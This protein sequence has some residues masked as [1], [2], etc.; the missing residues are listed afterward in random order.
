MKP[1]LVYLDSSDYSNFARKAG[2][3]TE[4]AAIRE[5]LLR[6]RDEGRIEVRYSFA[7]VVEV[8]PTDRIYTEA[9]RERMAQIELICGLKCFAAPQV[10]FASE[11]KALSGLNVQLQLLRDDGNWFPDIF[12]EAVDFPTAVEMI[13]EQISKGSRH[14][15]RTAKARYFDSRGQ[16]RTTVGNQI[17]AILPPLWKKLTDN[18]PFPDSALAQYQEYFLGRSPKETVLEV[19]KSSLVDLQ[20]FSEWYEKKWDTV[21]PLSMNLRA[22]GE[23]MAKTLSRTQEAGV[24]VLEDLTR[25][26]I[27]H[28]EVERMK[29]V[30]IEEMMDTFP[31]KLACSVLQTTEPPQLDA[32]TTPATLTIAS[33][34]ATLMRLTG[35]DSSVS[36]RRPLN[37]DTIDLLHTAYLPFVDIFRADGFMAEV[38]RKANLPFATTVVG[39]ISQLIP[40]VEKTLAD[41]YFSESSETTLNDQG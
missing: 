4:L 16:I 35:L 23:N 39:N 8:A 5:Q 26:G 27:S 32:D 1:V 41:R 14:E 17:A 13:H 31:A 19:L 7:H 28:D 36:R 37:S 9:A 38:I 25:R 11:S 33:A 10:I 15:R 21:S 30:V 29:R 24:R 18:Y 34:A 3:G 40:V 2:P 12:S 20:L 22:S 6:W